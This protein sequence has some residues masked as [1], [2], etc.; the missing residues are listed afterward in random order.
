M[1]KY[2][3]QE[4]VRLLGVKN[5]TT[6]PE[7]NRDLFSYLTRRSELGIAGLALVA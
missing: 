4:C 6:V 5:L 2:K 3:C 7:T 1:I